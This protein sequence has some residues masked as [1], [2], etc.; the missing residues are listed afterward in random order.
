MRAAMERIIENF[1]KS[2]DGKLSPEDE[3]QVAAMNAVME[4]RIR[5]V[6]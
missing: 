4:Q 1:V 3:A 2:K 6:S 5:D